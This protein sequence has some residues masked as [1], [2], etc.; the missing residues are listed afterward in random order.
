MQLNHSTQT[1]F[2]KTLDYQG[3]QPK[4]LCLIWIHGW[5]HNHQMMMALASGFTAVAKNYLIDLP[6]FGRSR[7]PTEA[8]TSEQYALCINEWIKKNLPHQN[9][10]VIGHSV[11]GRIALHI[12]NQNK[13]SIKG[14]V[15]L[16][17]SGLKPKRSIAFQLK[18]LILKN[19]SAYMKFIEKIGHFNLTG[20]RERFG[21]RFGSLDYR[22]SSGIMRSIFLNMVKEDSSMAARQIAQPTLLIFGTQDKEAPAEC[23]RRYAQL[24]QQSKYIELNHIDH[25][26]FLSTARH[27]V[28]RLIDEWLKKAPC[29]IFTGSQNHES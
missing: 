13:T 4:P 16:A 15:L 17:A 25:Y 23:G 6:G 21:Q 3:N 5:G 18:S 29:K 24:I 8:W 26:Q 9:I 27:Q 11:G 19:L 22:Q 28:Q 1:L 10:I 20:L 7:V 12:A 14:L 2:V